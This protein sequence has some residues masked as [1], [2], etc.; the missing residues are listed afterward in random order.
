MFILN[1]IGLKI[2]HLILINRLILRLQRKT[3]NSVL[4]EFLSNL[5]L[6]PKSKYF[7]LSHLFNVTRN[8]KLQNSNSNLLVNPWVDGSVDKA[9]ICAALESR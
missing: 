4:D 2:F 8:Q 9:S 5:K 3:D 7:E 6:K 1:V